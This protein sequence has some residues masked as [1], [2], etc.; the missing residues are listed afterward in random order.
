MPDIVRELPAELQSELTVALGAFHIVTPSSFAFAGEP[1]IDTVANP[2]GMGWVGAGPTAPTG[3]TADELL[4]KTVQSTLYDRCYAHRLGASRPQA[5]AATQEDPAF[6]H[7]L[8]EANSGKEHWD[9]GWT[10]F[11]F[12]AN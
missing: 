7:L 6:A 9:S 3:S 1:P 11:Q 2:V 8:A 12:G 10:I 5:E 4:V